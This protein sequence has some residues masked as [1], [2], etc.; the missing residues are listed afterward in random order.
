MVYSNTTVYGENMVNP[1]T[2]V[3][4]HFYEALNDAFEALSQD[5]ILHP[6]PVKEQQGHAAQSFKS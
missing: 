2:C 1:V 5:F 3:Y 6:I 4:F